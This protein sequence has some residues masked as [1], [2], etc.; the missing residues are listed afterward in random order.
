M[1]HA[2]ITTALI[3]GIRGI[4]EFAQTEQFSRASSTGFYLDFIL[5][6]LT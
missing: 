6:S 5:P 4:Q 3:C 1:M 2:E